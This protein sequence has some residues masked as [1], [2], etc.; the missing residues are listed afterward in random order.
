MIKKI[1]DIYKNNKKLVYTLIAI[2]T[3]IE[4]GTIGYFV[5][6]KYFSEP[7]ISK[8]IESELNSDNSSKISK[9]LS[10]IKTS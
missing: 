2:K 8:T 1:Q 5:N 4:M 9:L 6:K 3:T 10:K 7:P